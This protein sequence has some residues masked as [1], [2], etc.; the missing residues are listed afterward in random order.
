MSIK[1]ANKLKELRKVNDYSLDKLSEIS[2]ISKSYLWELENPRNFK[3]PIN[4]SIEKLTKIAEVLGVS[5]D[6]LLSEMF[7]TKKNED[8]IRKEAFFRKYESLD[9]DAKEKLDQILEMWIKK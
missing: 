3:K 4:P 5:T 6:E 2:G 1:L 9:T 8:N 7:E